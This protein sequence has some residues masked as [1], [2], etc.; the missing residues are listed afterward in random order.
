M[1]QKAGQT[2]TLDGITHVYGASK[3]VDCVTLEIVA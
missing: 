1:E 2:L 3:A